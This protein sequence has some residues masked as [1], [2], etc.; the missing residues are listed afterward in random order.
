MANH[1]NVDCSALALRKD[2]PSYIVGLR[3]ATNGNFSLL[4]DKCQTEVCNALWGSGNPDISGVG[5]RS[6]IATDQCCFPMLI[7]LT[8]DGW[9]CS[10]K[11]IWLWFQP[12]LVLST[13]P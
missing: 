6:T 13:S 12:D 2:F 8:D 4:S 9:L 10:R 5:V 7:A 1:S 3:N 11:R